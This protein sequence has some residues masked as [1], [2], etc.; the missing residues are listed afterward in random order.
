M[1]MMSMP[2]CHIS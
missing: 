2:H 1:P